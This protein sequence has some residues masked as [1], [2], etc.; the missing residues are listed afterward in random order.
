MSSDAIVNSY[1]QAL[2]AVAKNA[3]NPGV[4]SYEIN[5]VSKIFANEEVISFFKNPSNTADTKVSIAKASLEGKCLAETYNYVLLLVE[6]E[7]VGLALQINEKFQAMIRSAANEEEGI[8]F[9]A[10]DVSDDFKSQVEEK[11]SVSL[12]KKIK[13][14]VQNDPNLLS[15]YKVTVGGWTIDDSAQAHINKLKENILKRGF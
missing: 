1:S 2:F 11:L 4:F 14:N 7:R 10:T 12:N 5:T 3:K 6:N 13:L 9:S 8:L 15:G